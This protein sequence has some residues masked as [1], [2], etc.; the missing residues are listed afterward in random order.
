[1]KPQIEAAPPMSPY[2]I[3]AYSPD[4]RQV[5]IVEVKSGKDSDPQQ[6]ERVRQALMSVIEAQS[7]QFFVLAQR[8]GLFLWKKGAST[9]TDAEFAPVKG[10]LRE[11]AASLPDQEEII[12]KPGLE[13]VIHA[14]L[15]DLAL[16]IRQPKPD[17]E[18][19]QLLVKTG[20]YDQI[21][22]G[23]VVMESRP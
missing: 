12:R 3:T 4:N 17:S 13:M 7:V 16:G 8:N 19:D 9:G 11:Y 6:L 5:L 22:Q 20:I 10:L 23:R 21:R 14:W 1:M 15:D 18:A 2:D